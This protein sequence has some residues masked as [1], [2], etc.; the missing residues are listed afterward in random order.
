ML[1]EHGASEATEVHKLRFKY[2]YQPSDWKSVRKSVKKAKK[3]PT[4]PVLP[5]K[6]PQDR[7][8]CSDKRVFGLMDGRN[9]VLAE[10]LEGEHIRGQ[11][12]WFS[13]YEIGLRIKG[14][15]NL[16]LFRHALRNLGAA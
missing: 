7:Y 9:E 14:D 12:V 16:S 6:R 13:R 11:V 10:L 4:E 2:G 15:V 3:K 5:A 8:S 1:M